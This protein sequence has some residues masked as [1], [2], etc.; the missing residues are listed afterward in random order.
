MSD[1]KV[2]S[3]LIGALGG[4]GGGVLMD[5]IVHCARMSGLAVQATSV[6]GVA[7]RTGCLLYTSDAADD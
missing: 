1:T 4:E 2:R 3:I 6:P 7:Q 5:W